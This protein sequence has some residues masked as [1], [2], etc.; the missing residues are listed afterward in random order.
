MFLFCLFV[1]FAQLAEDTARL[2]NENKEKLLLKND[3]KAAFAEY[4]TQ[5]AEALKNMQQMDI[6]NEEQAKIITTQ[7]EVI[8][9]S[10][11]TEVELDEKRG[12]A[13]QTL[14]VQLPKCF[15]KNGVAF[16]ANR[17]PKYLTQ[18]RLNRN[19]EFVVFLDKYGDKK[20][21]LIKLSL[22]I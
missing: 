21:A 2:H 6:V 3:P 9:N 22:C 4:R 7:H 13:V 12:R 11:V 20:T 10:C 14:L 19:L 18:A 15:Q 16:I 17:T 1:C 5:M 8:L